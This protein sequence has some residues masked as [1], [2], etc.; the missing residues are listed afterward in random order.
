[1]Y[2]ETI[3]TAM[4]RQ[5]L[6]HG[7]KR[8]LPLQECKGTRICLE[9]CLSVSLQCFFFFFS[10]KKFFY[11][12]LQKKVFKNKFNRFCFFSLESDFK[13]PV[14]HLRE[15]H[16]PSVNPAARSLYSPVVRFVTPTKDSKNCCHKHA[17]WVYPYI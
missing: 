5:R 3:P 1:M 8:V 13:T 9:H 7:R 6:R 16:Y 10:L 15:R 12:C 14:R 2:C 17:T 11:L 4:K